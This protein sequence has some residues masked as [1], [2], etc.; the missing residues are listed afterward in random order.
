MANN[1]LVGRGIGMRV[2][3]SPSGRGGSVICGLL[4]IAALHPLFCLAQT[5]AQPPIAPVHPVTDD[6]FGTKIVDP[7]QWM[8]ALDAPTVTWMKSQ[9]AYTRAVLDS[10]APRQALLEKISAY[11][12]AFGM[13]TSVQVYG[14]RTFYL[15]RVPGADSYDLMVREPKGTVTTLVDVSALSAAHGGSPFAINY[16]AASPDGRLVAAGISE[17]GSEDASLSVY[18]VATGQ[19]VAG[20]LSG[21][22]FGLVSWADDGSLLFFNRLAET[23][24]RAAR[25]L[26][27]MAVVWNLKDPPVPLYGG[28][29]GHGPKVAPAQIPQL[30]RWPGARWAAAIISNGVQ[31]ELQIWL[32]PVERAAD[33]AAPWQQLTTY[34]DGVTNVEISG[35]RVFLLSHQDAPTFKVLTLNAGQSLSQASALLS[36]DPHCIV[37][38]IHAAADGLYVATRAGIYSKLLRV[39]LGGGTPLEIALPFQGA[40]GEMFGDP[41]APGVTLLLESFVRPPAALRYDPGSKRFIDQ[42]LTVAPHYE[43]SRF[44]LSNLTARA[45]DGVRV[46]L[47]LIRPKGARSGAP[48]LLSAY[49]SYGI[50]TL[51]NF[52]PLWIPFMAMGASTAYCHVRGGG[53]LGE[54]WRLAGKDANKPNTWRDL[55]ACAETLIARG[56]ATRHSLFIRGGSAGGITVGRAMEERPELFA[57]VID[58]VPAANTLRAEIEAN[59]PANI[60]EF[61]TNKTPQGFSNLLAMDSYLGVRDGVQYPPILIATGLN[62]PRVDPWEPAKLAARLQASGSRAPVLLRVVE[63][64][65]HGIGSTKTQDDELAADIDAFVFWHAGLKAWQPARR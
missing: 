26:N 42:A 15:N 37:E 39:P 8:E 50:S 36:A 55:I 41:R 6:Y 33:T 31:N 4:W 35:E 7:Y 56:V 64:A 25:F 51:P 54:S 65:G 48:V 62:D 47:T 9:G 60:P 40:I 38:S 19:R 22:R 16:Y 52:R 29:A 13:V 3:Q 44:V 49:G 46:P 1:K 23:A 18:E 2:S 30:A 12:G 61:G 43:A 58:Q 17:G 24:D 59:G 5:L 10:I 32:T 14:G 34:E 63:D 53:E 57:G 21:A 27:S 28:T 11:T 45:R 20:P